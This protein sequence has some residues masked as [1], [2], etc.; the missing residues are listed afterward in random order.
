MFLSI[1][2]HN[3]NLIPWRESGANVQLI[4]M[5][6]TGDLDYQILESKLKAYQ[7]YNSLKICSITSGSNITGIMTDTD[8]IAVM[9]HKAGFLS[10]FDTAGM[11]PY[12]EINMNGLA[13]HY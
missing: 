2:E 3:A 5:T 1:F 12:A 7:N 9:C 10:F 6:E 4:P 8:R 13:N 11:C